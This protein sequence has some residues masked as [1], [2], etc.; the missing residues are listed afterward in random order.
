[1]RGFYTLVAAATL[2]SSAAAKLEPVT[3]KGNTFFIG[4][5]RV[6]FLAGS[7]LNVG[8]CANFC[9]SSTSVVLAISRVDRP[10]WLIPLRILRTA[11]VIFRFSRSSVSMLFVSVS[12]LMLVFRHWYVIDRIITDTVDNSANHD[13]CMKEL[14]DAGIYLLLV[15]FTFAPF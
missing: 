3:V 7:P 5:E 15:G 10:T 6:S 4:D 11:S 9:V 8:N 12:G 1:M 14:D 2:V 13:E